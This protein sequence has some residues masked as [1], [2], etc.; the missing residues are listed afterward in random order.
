MIV[1]LAGEERGEVIKKVRLD[2]ALMYLTYF[3]SLFL[4]AAVRSA[5]E[6]NVTVEYRNKIHRFTSRWRQLYTGR[7]ANNRPLPFH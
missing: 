3:F 6:K 1:E 7:D 5:F 4:F 2:R